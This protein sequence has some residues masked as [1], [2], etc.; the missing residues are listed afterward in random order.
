MITLS[1][2]EGGQ[3]TRHEDAYILRSGCVAEI[4][5]RAFPDRNGR[6]AEVFAHAHTRPAVASPPRPTK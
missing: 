2:D 1:T 4:C 3:R 5:T 6:S